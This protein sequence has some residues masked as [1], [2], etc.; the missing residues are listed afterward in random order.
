MAVRYGH[1]NHLIGTAINL[2][3]VFFDFAVDSETK[4]TNVVGTFGFTKKS[5]KKIS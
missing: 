4:V 1:E 2:I 5:Y 3:D